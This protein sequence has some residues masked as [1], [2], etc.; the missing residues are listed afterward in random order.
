MF[1]RQGLQIMKDTAITAAGGAGLTNSIWLPWLPDA[2]QFLIAA[3]GF[4]VLVATLYSKY[5]EIR[6][7]KQ[8]LSEL[9]DKS[10]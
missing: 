1:K 9:R 7:K 5:L 2:W 3:L 4:L 10:K 6:I 8:T